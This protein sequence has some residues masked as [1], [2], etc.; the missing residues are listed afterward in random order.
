MVSQKYNFSKLPLVTRRQQGLS[1]LTDLQQ[2][3]FRLVTSL[4][5]FSV[6]VI[7]LIAR[8]CR[9]GLVSVRRGKQTPSAPT[10]GLRV[11]VCY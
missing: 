6:L 7:N 10:D 5:A 3:T 8:L 1:Y 11:A 9:D 4:F 2:Y